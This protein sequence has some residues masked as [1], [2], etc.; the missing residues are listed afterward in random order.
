MD[1]KS[2][3]VKWEWHRSDLTGIILKKVDTA[4]SF[5]WHNYCRRRSYYLIYSICLQT[6]KFPNSFEEAHKLIKLINWDY[7]LKILSTDPLCLRSWHQ[8]KHL[9]STSVGHRRLN[10]VQCR[11]IFAQVIRHVPIG[12]DRQQI[13]TAVGDEQ[14]KDEHLRNITFYRLINVL[15][16]Q[17]PWLT[18]GLY[19]EKF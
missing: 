8:F 18:W 9:Y 13:C 12:V 16:V 6:D 19:E 14:I 2:E 7:S 5:Q 11:V 4:H 3:M 17:Y 1:K 15:N 10:D